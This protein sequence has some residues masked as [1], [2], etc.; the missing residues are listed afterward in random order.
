M[1]GLDAWEQAW[2]E[3]LL[4]DE[5]AGKP[6][7]LTLSEGGG[8]P[9]L[10]PS[11]RRIWLQ[12]AR[13]GRTLQLFSHLPPRLVCLLGEDYASELLARLPLSLVTQA[14]LNHFKLAVLVG[15]Q[16]VLVEESVVIPH[17]EQVLAYEVSVLQLNYHALPQNLNL[18]DAPT[19]AEWAC[20]LSAGP[21]FVDVLEFLRQGQVPPPCSEFPLQTYLLT[22]DLAGSRLEPLH[23][24]VA[25]CL[26]EVDGQRF[27]SQIVE[28]VLQDYSGPPLEV[29]ALMEWLSYLVRRGILRLSSAAELD[30]FLKE[31]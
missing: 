14:G 21:H 25:A 3:W 13:T 24:L 18:A 4:L 11:E 30:L 16:A 28:S 23:P 15:L 6:V 20:L 19:W 9:V 27:W 10:V 26:A 8:V 1:T 7:P 29:S 5:Q 12:T 31:T 22:R 17:L 2:E